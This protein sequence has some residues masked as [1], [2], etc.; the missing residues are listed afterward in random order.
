MLL[1]FIYIYINAWICFSKLHF[2]NK[3]VIYKINKTHDLIAQSVRMSERNS[4]IVG[5]NP[6]EAN[7]LQLLLKILPW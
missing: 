4:V 3:Y 5:S 2:I 6:T 1:A 7:F